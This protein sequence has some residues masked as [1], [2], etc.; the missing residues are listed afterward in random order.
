VER[1]STSDLHTAGGD[2]RYCAGVIGQL[3]PHI[4]AINSISISKKH[5]QYSHKQ[6][7]MANNYCPN[8]VEM[9]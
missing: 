9:E 3:L 4:A 6:L 2:A 1:S 8:E 5:S 7:M